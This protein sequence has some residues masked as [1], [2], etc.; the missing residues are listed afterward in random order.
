MRLSGTLLLP[1]GLETGS[2][3]RKE[4]AL[5]G[6]RVGGSH[7]HGGPTCLQIGIPVDGAR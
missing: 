1:R 6:S 4:A 7:A 3:L 5:G 2:N